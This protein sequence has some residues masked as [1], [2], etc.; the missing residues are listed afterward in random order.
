M[1]T[2]ERRA[3]LE[4]HGF[5]VAQKSFR[6]SSGRELH[7][8]LQLLPD[9]SRGTEQSRAEFESR[10]YFVQLDS[11]DWQRWGS[12]VWCTFESGPWNELA[13]QPVPI[14]S[15]TAV[16]VSANAAIVP[17]TP[18][19]DSV[20]KSTADAELHPFLQHCLQSG[21]TWDDR[22]NAARGPVDLGNRWLLK[23]GVSYLALPRNQVLIDRHWQEHRLETL[24]AHTPAPV[25]SRAKPFVSMKQQPLQITGNR[26][27]IRLF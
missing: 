5:V 16:T 19:I 8:L 23:D 13:E 9:G 24:A 18:A 14:V 15:P 6:G 27:Q 11:G 26:K 4:Q 17:T 1:N 21:F 2:F 12:G 25:A 10:Q 22:K 3:L 20:A 7:Y